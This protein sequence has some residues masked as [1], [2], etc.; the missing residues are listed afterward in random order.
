VVR[1]SPGWV[2]TEGAVGL[3]NELA[4][5]NGT[6]Y[7]SARKA[8]MDSL[9]GIP[10]KTPSPTKR[11]SGAHRISRLAAC[12]LNHWHGIQNRR[13][14]RANSMKGVCLRS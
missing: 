9:G 14:H 5:R 11:S 10:I 7:E 13:R 2:E 1:V 3:V 8:L 6:D 12:R 4:A